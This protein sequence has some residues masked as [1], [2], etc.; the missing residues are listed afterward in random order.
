MDL[1]NPHPQFIFNRVLQILDL[2]LPVMN[3][4]EKINWKKY[5]VSTFRNVIIKSIT[6]TDTEST[7]LR[8]STRVQAN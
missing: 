7:E 8:S 2:S 5:S 6:N 1:E 4:T 3:N